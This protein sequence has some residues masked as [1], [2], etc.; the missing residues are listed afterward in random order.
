[1]ADGNRK[2]WLRCASSGCWE[3]V[4]GTFAGVSLCLMHREELARTLGAKAS[5]L[6]YY[7]TWDEGQTVKIGMSTSPTLRFKDH[8]QSAGRPVQI[9]AAHPGGR[10][11]E[12]A[13]HARFRHLLVQ[14]EREVFRAAPELAEHLSNLT[15][16]WPNWRE[17]VQSVDAGSRATRSV[18][19]KLA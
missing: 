14:G 12:S 18:R 7:L 5:S 8:A 17:L 11:E 13:Q 10:Q 4:V 3:P 9:L 6:V 19:R 2:P 16:L 15:H 1:M